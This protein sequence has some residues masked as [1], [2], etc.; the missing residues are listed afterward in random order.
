MIDIS[1]YLEIF[2]LIVR[3]LTYSTH[4]YWCSLT[5]CF[6]LCSVFCIDACSMLVIYWLS[7]V[8]VISWYQCLSSLASKIFGVR[9]ITKANKYICRLLEWNFRY[10]HIIIQEKEGALKGL[11]PPIMGWKKALLDH[12]CRHTRTSCDETMTP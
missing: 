10:T 9:S 7:L 6:F 2:M 8:I 5:W 11:N 4:K 12:L 1:F 3:V